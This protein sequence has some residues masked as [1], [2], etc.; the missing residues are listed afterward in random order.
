MRTRAAVALAAGQPLEVLEVMEVNLEG[1]PGHQRATHRT[2]VVSKCLSF[3]RICWTNAQ[4]TARLLHSDHAAPELLAYERLL[5]SRNCRG[6][7]PKACL[8][9]LLN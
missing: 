5:F 2:F 1:P 8:N 7:T 4:S 9:F 3:G 6:D